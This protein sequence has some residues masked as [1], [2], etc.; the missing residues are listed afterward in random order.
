MGLSVWFSMLSNLL[1]ACLASYIPHAGPILALHQ[2]G[3]LLFPGLGTITV[4]ISVLTLISEG[5]ASADGK[6]SAP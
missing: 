5:E 2:I 3:D 4:L 6:A 1:G